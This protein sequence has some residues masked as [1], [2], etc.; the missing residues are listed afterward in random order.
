VEIMMNCRAFQAAVDE[1]LDG[2][3]A[4]DAEEQARAHLAECARCR[5]DFAD[6]QGA[7]AALRSMPET[8]MPEDM[9]ES[10]RTE[11]ARR[12]SEAA[13][14][15]WDRLLYPWRRGLSSVCL[16]MILFITVVSTNATRRLQKYVVPAA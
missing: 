7:I 14:G 2:S 4:P 8:A 10:F 13:L 12:D 15:V 1:L 11:A 16:G 6:L 5:Q 9:W 3:L